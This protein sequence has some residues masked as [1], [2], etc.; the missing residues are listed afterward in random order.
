VWESII[1][2]QRIFQ[3]ILQ[4]RI[5]PHGENVQEDLDRILNLIQINRERIFASTDLLMFLQQIEAEI[6][7]LKLKE[8]NKTY[9]L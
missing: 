8:K 9:F 7:V 2:V 4:V 6:L 1:D 5:C 3:T